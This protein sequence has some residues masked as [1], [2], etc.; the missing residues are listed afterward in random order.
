MEDNITV[1]TEKARILHSYSLLKRIE[2]FSYTSSVDEGNFSTV[3]LGR[4]FTSGL[5]SWN[6]TESNCIDQSCQF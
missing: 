2:E 1:D 5:T 6:E 4:G 3:T